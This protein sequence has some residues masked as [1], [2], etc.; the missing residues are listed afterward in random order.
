MELVKILPE[1]AMEKG[2]TLSDYDY[3]EMPSINNGE[4]EISAA[5]DS[6][7]TKGITFVSDDD[8][9]SWKPRKND[10]L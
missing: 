2:Y 1:T 7:E 10:F 3:Y 9:E 6:S 4:L 5:I 8:G